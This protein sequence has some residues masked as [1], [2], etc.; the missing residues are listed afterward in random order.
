M[1]LPILYQTNPMD[2]LVQI[3]WFGFI[4]AFIGYVILWKLGWIS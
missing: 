4:F 3:L 2:Y 1:L